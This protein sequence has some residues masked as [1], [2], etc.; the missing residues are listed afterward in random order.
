[1]WCHK[2]PQQPLQPQQGLDVGAAE[3]P[4]P[5][6]RD[7]TSMAPELFCLILHKVQER[8]GEEGEGRRIVACAGVCRSWRTQVHQFCH[9]VCHAPFIQFP[10][11]L[12]QPGPVVS[13][14]PLPRRAPVQCVVRRKGSLITLYHGDLEHRQFMLAARRKWRP[15][16]WTFVISSH[17]RCFSERSHGFLGKLKANFWASDFVLWG[18]NK[19]NSVRSPPLTGIFFSED[20]ID[21]VR[22]RRIACVLTPPEQAPASGCS[23]PFPLPRSRSLAGSACEIALP[24]TVSKTG[25]AQVGW[26]LRSL[27]SFLEV[28]SLWELAYRPV[29]CWLSSNV[30]CVAV[31]M[32][33]VMAG[34]REIVVHV[35]Y[36]RYDYVQYT[37]SYI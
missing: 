36:T 33:D 16:G 10:S 9:T 24:R 18:A 19:R 1:M 12:S 4:S 37:R 14:G 21:G 25:L 7:W 30:A 34:W 3:D 11:S 5:G 13:G 28:T 20:V 27:F 6:H 8:R 2:L 22:Q 35:H 32:A 23:L 26:A 17:P 15:G 31:V 29:R